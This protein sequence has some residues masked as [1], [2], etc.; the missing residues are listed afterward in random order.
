VRAVVVD[1]DRSQVRTDRGAQAMARLL[2]FAISCLRLAGC[3]NI[4]RALRRIAA[5]WRAPLSRL[6][7]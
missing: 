1:E 5:D 2:T 6:G 3:V 4:A 7:L